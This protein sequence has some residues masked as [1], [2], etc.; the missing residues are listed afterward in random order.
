LEEKKKIRKIKKENSER[1][2][3]FLLYHLRRNIKKL[4]KIKG[5][6]CAKCINNSG[7]IDI[8]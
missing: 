4:L 8:L 2:F 3:L 5:I 1:G 6:Y 7:E